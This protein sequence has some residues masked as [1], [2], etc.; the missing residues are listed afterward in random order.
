MDEKKIIHEERNMETNKEQIQHGE[1][2]RQ[3]HHATN[4]CR[5]TKKMITMKVKF[6]SAYIWAMCAVVVL[7]ATVMNSCS[8]DDDYDLYQGDELK[9]YAAVTRAG[10]ES[11]IGTP[12]SCGI[13]CIAE[14]SKGK[15]Y[16][17]VK[18][19][20]ERLKLPTTTAMTT[21][22]LLQLAQ[23]AGLPCSNWLTNS[24]QIDGVAYPDTVTNLLKSKGA[25]GKFSNVI[26]GYNYHYYVA[27]ELVAGGDKIK[28]KDPNLNGQTSN[29]NTSIF[30]AVVY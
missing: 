2:S 28:V 26:L 11:G 17:D 21:S 13:W 30:E 10:S 27:V 20:A 6:N 25:N 8:S 23:G 14:L 12:Q 1:G 3:P 19:I 22:Q 7:S 4:N 16:E 15:D 18:F 9:T 5:L 29:L 24:L